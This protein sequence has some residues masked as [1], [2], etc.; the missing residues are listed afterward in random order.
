MDDILDWGKHL[1]EW[2]RFRSWGKLWL[3]KMDGSSIKHKN[4]FWSPWLFK[5]LDTKFFDRDIQMLKEATKRH[6]DVSYRKKLKCVM[7]DIVWQF[8]FGEDI[9]KRILLT[10]AV[11]RG[12]AQK[13]MFGGRVFSSMSV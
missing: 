12:T 13:I 4:S 3:A 10:E 6:F 8:C 9:I 1:T 7:R 2:K 5:L 11:T